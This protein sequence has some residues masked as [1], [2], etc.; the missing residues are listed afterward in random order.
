ML[1]FCAQGAAVLALTS[2]L[3]PFPVA[4]AAAAVEAAVEA[5]VVARMGGGA[6]VVVLRR[7]RQRPALCLRKTYM[8]TKG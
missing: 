4:V 1:V 3:P 6:T 7:R 8:N 5:A 2:R